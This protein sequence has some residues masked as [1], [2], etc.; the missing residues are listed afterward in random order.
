MELICD[1]H[2]CTGCGACLNVCPTAAITMKEKKAGHIYPVINSQKCLNCGKC[3]KICPVNQSVL[4]YNP[5]T[6][7]AAWAKDDREH[8]SSTSGGAAAVFTNF[9]LEKGGVVYGSVFDGKFLH[10]RIDNREDT[11]KLKGSKYVHSHTERTFKEVEADLKGERWVLYIGTPCQIAGLRCYLE[12]EYERLVTVDLICHGVPSQKLLFEHLKSCGVERD[13][14]ENISFRNPNGFYL[15]VDYADR[16]Q[17]QK[18]NLDDLYYIAFSDNLTF[19]D[20]C[21]N[22]VYAKAV[23]VGDLTIGDFWGLGKEM[24]F[25][26]TVKNGISVIL[27]NS[28]K[29][30]ALLE[31][32]KKH[33]H[34]V[35]RTVNEAVKGNFNLRSPSFSKNHEIFAKKYERLGCE[36]ALKQCLRV[37]RMKYFILKFY[38]KARNVLK[39]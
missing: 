6:A 14:I 21:Y 5:T 39:K 30:R 15:T 3:Q 29:G 8:I 33:L 38:L 32:C 34:L 19:R 4:F 31:N 12:R 23:R 25:E 10:K 7:Y 13:K 20:S 37:K 18:R 27:V 28:E 2:L 16:Q 11:A 1:R 17:Y 26:Q 24:P 9:V 36:K 22:C 35:E